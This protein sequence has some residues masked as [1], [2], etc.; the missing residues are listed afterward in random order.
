MQ[1][2]LLLNLLQE[3]G[4]V[5]EYVIFHILET[6]SS[7]HLELIVSLDGVKETRICFLD[8]TV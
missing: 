2:F 4:D 6:I 1:G 5:G 8:D 7:C 3:F